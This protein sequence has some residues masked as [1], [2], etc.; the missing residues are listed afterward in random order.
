MSLRPPDKDLLT[1]ICQ[2][3]AKENYGFLYV[4]QVKDKIQS[5]YESGEKSRLRAQSLSASDI[6]EAMQTIAGDDMTGFQQIRSGVYYYD[7][8][9]MGD[10]SDIAPELT[11]LFRGQLVVTSEDVRDRFDLAIDDVEFFIRELRNR[12]LLLRIAAGNRDYYTVGSRLK[13]Q[14]DDQGLEGRL[15]NR[16]TNGKISHEQLEQAISVEA[17]SDVINYLQSE[18]YV[19]DLDGEYLVRSSLEEF[20]ANLARE[21]E[22]SVVEE[23]EEAGYVMPAKEYTQLLR[24]EIEDRSPILAKSRSVRNLSEE[25]LL[26]SVRDWFAS[27]TGPGIEIDDDDDVAIH[28]DLSEQVAAHAEE[29]VRPVLRDQTASRPS[30][31]LEEIEPDIEELQLAT[32]PDG[33]R[34]VRDQVREEAR[35]RIEEAF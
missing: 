21:I 29:L 32:T 22:E 14:T 8:F 19:I 6:K 34:Y 24:R 30:R 7:P 28:P 2:S 5:E 23:F 27:E 10:D 9:G 4:D 12:D 33:N 15:E 3:I 11:A 1:D 18:G 35:E 13:E 17:T 31:M 20:G 16:A 25:E 26:D